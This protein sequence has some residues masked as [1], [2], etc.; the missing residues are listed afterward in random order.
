MLCG[1]AG[2]HGL[3][4]GQ[5]TLA[6]LL[7]CLEHGVRL[8]RDVL[9]LGKRAKNETGAAHERRKAKEGPHTH[10]S[11]LAINRTLSPSFLRSRRLTA[12]TSSM[13]MRGR[14][15]KGSKVG[16]WFAP[17]AARECSRAWCRSLSRSLPSAS[18]GCSARARW[19]TAAR[20]AACCACARRKCWA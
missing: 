7:L 18:A 9:L 8:L 6:P 5:G 1:G 14:S 15:V 4:V 13:D 10:S 17:S 12:C 11:G 20:R 16:T 19:G 2:T 3:V